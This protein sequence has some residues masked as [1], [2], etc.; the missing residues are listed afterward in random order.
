MNSPNQNNNI[1]NFGSNLEFF[2]AEV[3]EKKFQF[4]FGPQKPNVDYALGAMKIYRT[5][6]IKL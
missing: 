2:D 1:A 3:L 4:G 5:L 6:Q